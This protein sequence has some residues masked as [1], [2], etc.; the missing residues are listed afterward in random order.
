MPA[1]IVKV[2]RDRSFV[3][4][5]PLQRREHFLHLIG[6]GNFF[7]ARSRAK[8]KASATLIPDD[9]AVKTQDFPCL[10]DDSGKDLLEVQRR[11]DL[12]RKIYQGIERRYLSFRFQPLRILQ[13]NRGLF[14]DAS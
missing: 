1:V 2:S 4:S 6:L 5:H 14:A 13:R 11:S 3:P 9:E 12:P 10:I 8:H 7:F